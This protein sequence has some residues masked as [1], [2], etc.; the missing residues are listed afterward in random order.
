[1]QQL[2][3]LYHYNPIY[4]H[5]AYLSVVSSSNE[6]NESNAIDY[7]AIAKTINEIRKTGIDVELPYIN[8]A[9][10][11]FEPD[12]NNNGILF[13]LK[14][15]NGINTEVA[16]I[17]INNRP[18]ASF[19]DFVEK[20]QLKKVQIINLIKSGAFDK[21]SNKTRKELLY[22]YLYSLAKETRKP[23][24]KITGACLTEI[25]DLGLIN[26]QD[27]R[28]NRLYN[29]NKYITA[30]E[31][32]YEKV[33]NKTWLLAK[34]RAYSFFEQNYL[35]EL[36]EEQE[37]YYS[38][39]GIVF[40]KNAY[41]KL[42]KSKLNPFIESLNT[43]EFIAKY[44]KAVYDSKAIVEF[45]KYCSGTEADWEMEALSFYHQDHALA[46]VNKAKYNFT[47]FAELPAEPIVTEEYEWKGRTFYRYQL[48]RI[49]GTVLDNNRTKHTITL[50]TPDNEIVTVKFYGGQFINYN[51]KITDIDENGKSITKENS[52]F[53]RGNKLAIVG[54]RRD[55]QFIPKVYKNSIYK[56]SVALITNVTADGNL[57]LQTLRYG[58]TE[59]KWSKS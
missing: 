43:P 44:N 47:T 6:G 12:I 8:S 45:N 30:K 51:K 9:M 24:E 17:I 33:K 48:N 40:S 20:T 26:S 29:F 50:L 39:E 35:D 53:K 42:F 18:Y 19:E 54:Y 4:S 28:Y 32:E 2:N 3:L 46:K 1:M 59:N 57:S 15:I 52:W 31:N 10:V 23:K 14:G 16:D 27:V 34:G 56:H 58:E 5:T 21:I 7:G 36:K 22:D 13:S 38:T 41:N 55:E 11:G 37:Y 49:C 25:C